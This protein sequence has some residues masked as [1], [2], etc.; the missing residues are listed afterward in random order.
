MTQPQ[1]LYFLRKNSR[2]ESINLYKCFCGKEFEC[3]PIRIRTGNTKS[4]GCLSKTKFKK[5]LT[6]HGLHGSANYGRWKAMMNRCYN[7]NNPAYKHYGAKGITVDLPWHSYEIFNDDIGVKPFDSATI[8]RIDVSKPYSKENCRWATKQMQGENRSD[9]YKIMYDGRI[10]TVR[11][12]EK[13]LKKDNETIRKM[14]VGGK[15]E[16]IQGGRK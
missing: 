9:V 6:K 16:V 8:D 11:S 1:L 4:C 5:M 7:K 13:I 10:E 3:I 12:L 15:L 14:C 2:Y